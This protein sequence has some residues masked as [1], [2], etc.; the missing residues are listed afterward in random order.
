MDLWISI[1]F[2]SDLDSAWTVLDVMR[3]SGLEPTADSYAALLQAHAEAGD[4]EGLQRTFKECETAELTLHDRD[5]LEAI[6]TLATRDHHGL[7]PQVGDY[8]WLLE[9]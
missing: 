6:F 1:C 8:L 4:A 3:S 9:N 7:I 5:L 2:F